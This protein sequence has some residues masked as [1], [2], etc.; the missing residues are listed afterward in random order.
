MRDHERAMLAYVKLAHLSQ[1]KRQFLGRDKFLILAAAAACRA[2]WLEVANR[3]HVLVLAHNP[4]H[5]I[6]HFELFTDALRSPELVPFL[7]RLERFCGYERAEHLL[8][9]LDVE[10]GL[11]AA[12]SSLSF[13]N[14]ALQILSHVHGTDSEVNAN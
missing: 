1:Q 7:K 11:P 3:C 14:Y 4:A 13:G 6:G 12:E 9:E 10:P 2:G 5:L 8:C